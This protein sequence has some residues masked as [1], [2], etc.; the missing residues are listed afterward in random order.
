M[1]K[2]SRNYKIFQNLLVGEN[3][4]KNFGENQ[5]KLQNLFVIQW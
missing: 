2:T 5:Y 3:A 4:W 1:W